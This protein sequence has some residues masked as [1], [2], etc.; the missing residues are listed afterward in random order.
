MQGHRLWIRLYPNSNSHKWMPSLLCRDN[1][2]RLPINSSLLSLIT[3]KI[4]DRFIATR[5]TWRNL[6]SKRMRTLW[7]LYTHFIDKV[8]QQRNTINFG[9]TCNRISKI[10]SD[11]RIH[12]YFDHAQ[13]NY[14]LLA[15]AFQENIP[16]DV[17][18]WAV[19]NV[20]RKVKYNGVNKRM[21]TID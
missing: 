16:V 5:C 19:H 6:R 4:R 12:F 18:T 13:A 14:Y 9:H 21:N 2:A 1:L 15:I 10:V 20:F 11:Q 3:R 7:S 17:L 8:M